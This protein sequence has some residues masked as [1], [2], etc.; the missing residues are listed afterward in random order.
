MENIQREVLLCVD[1]LFP[2]HLFLTSVRGKTLYTTQPFNLIQ[3]NCSHTLQENMKI[4]KQTNKNNLQMKSP[5]CHFKQKTFLPF[6]TG[7]IQIIQS[8][9]IQVNP[10]LFGHPSTGTAQHSTQRFLVWC[11]QPGAVARQNITFLMKRRSPKIFSI[12]I[13]TS[14]S[15]YTRPSPTSLRAVPSRWEVLSVARKSQ[16]GLLILERHKGESGSGKLQGYF[17]LIRHFVFK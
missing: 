5:F 13:S 8:T 17:G 9:L 15:W 7:D 3:Y 1:S 12:L 6:H 10:F 16:M 11:W 2:I 4:K 14:R